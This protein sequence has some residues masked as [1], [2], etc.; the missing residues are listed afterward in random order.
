MKAIDDIEPWSSADRANWE[1]L[2]TRV[3]RYL[4]L[5][6]MGSAD[7]RRIGP[8]LRVRASKAEEAL[9]W[10]S[11][12]GTVIDAVVDGRVRWGLTAQG[13]EWLRA[14]GVVTPPAPL[15]PLPAKE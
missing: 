1:P 3:A 8:I 7:V 12:E 6:P 2:A 13:I 14:R 5:G 4:L 11:M 15:P 9:H 10:A